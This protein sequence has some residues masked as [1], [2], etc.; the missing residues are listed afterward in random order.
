MLKRS[1]RFGVGKEIGGAVYVHR[2]YERLLPKRVVEASQSLPKDFD[3][4]VVKF[5]IKDQRTSFICCQDFDTADEP[6]VGD[7]IIVYP[8]N[9]HRHIKKHADPWI[10]HHKW[11]FVKDD[12]KGFDVL[13]SHERSK[14][15]MKL[16]ELDSRRIGKR[17]FWEKHGLPFLFPVID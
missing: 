11:L 16:P 12:Y 9:T 15:I 3:Y 8:D 14:K 13:H 4:V 10:Y 2:L 1:K 17:S 5:N 7:S 6:T